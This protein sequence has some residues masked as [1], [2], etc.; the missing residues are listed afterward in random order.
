MYTD[1]IHAAPLDNFRVQV[2]LAD[3]RKGIFD[4]KPHLNW[5][6]YRDLRDPAY[7]RSVRV[8]HGVLCWPHDE[9]VAPERLEDE[10]Q[11]VS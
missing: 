10:L 11:E 5:N 3:G 9:D 4:L 8:E 1:V 7:F 6:A 2:E